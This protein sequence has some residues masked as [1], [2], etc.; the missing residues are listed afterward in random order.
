MFE[1]GG[2]SIQG[3]ADDNDIIEGSSIYLHHGCLPRESLLFE[4]LLSQ[5][6]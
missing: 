3:A 5:Q 4:Y 2:V 6:K 1:G